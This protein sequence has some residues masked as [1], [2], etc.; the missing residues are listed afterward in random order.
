MSTNPNDVIEVAARAEFEGVEDTVNVYQ[1]QYTGPAAC[2]DFETILDLSNRLDGLYAPFASAQSTS[3]LYRDLT[4]R[5]I[6]QSTLLGVTPWPARTAGSSASNNLPPGVAVVV[7][8]GTS[9]ARVI[10]RKFIGGFTAA[11]L[12]PNGTFTSAIT[13]LVVTF[14]ST[15]ISPYTGGGTR[16]WQYGYFS[17][18]AAGFVIPT[19]ATVTDIPGYQRRRKQG[20]GV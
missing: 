15:L 17:P 10:L 3:Y 16:T 13:S 2:T 11:V 20:R 4:F 7:N 9:I 12:D 18:K 6:T 8:A 5:N 19:S 14:A 1:F